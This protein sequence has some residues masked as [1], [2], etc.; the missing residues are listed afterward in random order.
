[1]KVKRMPWFLYG[2]CF[3]T[4]ISN[5]VCI[6]IKYNA[7]FEVLTAT[8]LRFRFSGMQKCVTAWVDPDILRDLHT[9]KMKAIQ[10]FILMR[11]THPTIQCQIAA[12]FN[13]H[14]IKHLP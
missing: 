13:I 2:I 3:H 8:L 5:S 14:H 10:S 6:N 4:C 11:T 7:R 1:M 9:L 12:N